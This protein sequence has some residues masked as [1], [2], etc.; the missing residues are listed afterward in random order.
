MLN[1]EEVAQ[2]L[3]LAQVQDIFN[4]PASDGLRTYSIKLFLLWISE[5]FVT[6]ICTPF[7][8]HHSAHLQGSTL[9]SSTSPETVSIITIFLR[10]SQRWRQQVDALS[11]HKYCA[12]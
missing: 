3:N 6:L 1:V 4:N 2:S 8:P 9:Y 7:L 11:Y 10:L 5:T 12:N